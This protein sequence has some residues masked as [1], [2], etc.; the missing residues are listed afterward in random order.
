MAPSRTS[1]TTSALVTPFDAYAAG[2]STNPQNDAHAHLRRFPFDN[3][4]RTAVT[5]A[6]IKSAEERLSTV[7]CQWDYKNYIKAHASATGDFYDMPY[8]FRYYSRIQVANGSTEGD[9]QWIQERIRL[10]EDQ[11]RNLGHDLVS[12]QNQEETLKFRLERGKKVINDEIKAVQEAIKDGQ[13][14]YREMDEKEL[15]KN[16]YKK[17][18][19]IPHFKNIRH[20]S[21]PELVEHKHSFCSRCRTKGHLPTHHR[22]VKCPYCR[23]TAPGHFPANCSKWQEASSLLES[24]P[25]AAA[26]VSTQPTTD[27]TSPVLPS[28]NIERTRHRKNK[29]SAQ[30]KAKKNSGW[31]RPEGHQSYFSDDHFGEWND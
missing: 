15:V 21:Q 2:T 3:T 30:K 11:I 19:P 10:C 4:L 5:P 20:L 1:K 17:G 14:V 29:K 6:E 28:P 13:L 26:A 27:T 16:A 9:I 31:S 22:D 25:A 8:N 18:I 23:I 7:K 24:I 12:L